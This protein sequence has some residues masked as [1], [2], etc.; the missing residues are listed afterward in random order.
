MLP[1]YPVQEYCFCKG[2]PGSKR[3]TSSLPS[4]TLIENAT[5]T[6]RQTENLCSNL[7]V[8]LSVDATPVYSFF[9]V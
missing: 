1:P 7:C 6:K 8:S 2:R 4:Q 5:R 9:F 3:T